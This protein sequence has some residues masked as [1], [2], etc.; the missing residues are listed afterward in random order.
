MTFL[1]TFISNHAQNRLQI[2]RLY[3]VCYKNGKQRL[4]IFQL[5]GKNLTIVE[6]ILSSTLNASF[7]L[8]FLIIV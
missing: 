8:L 2:L 4:D 7:Q 6:L 1:P 3:F 5:K